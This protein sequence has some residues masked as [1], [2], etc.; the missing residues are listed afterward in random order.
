MKNNPKTEKKLRNYR[1]IF[2]DGSECEFQAAGLKEAENAVRDM[3]KD[4]EELVEL[5]S[6]PI[7]EERLEGPNGEKIEEVPVY[8]KDDIDRMLGISIDLVG[9]YIRVQHKMLTSHLSTEQKER[10]ENAFH[11]LEREAS[12][13]NA[14]V[15]AYDVYVVENE[16][17]VTVIE[18]TKTGKSD[19][20]TNITSFLAMAR[21]VIKETEKMLVSYE[22]KRIFAHLFEETCRNNSPKDDE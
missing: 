7:E 19:S 18:F 6:S 2:Q 22:I 14:S 13:E 16:E 9:D 5:H 3:Q 15:C 12:E 11:M 8:S 1:V 21:A 4:P 20:I 17:T 10:V